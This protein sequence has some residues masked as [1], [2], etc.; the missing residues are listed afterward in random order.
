M[1]C[2]LKIESEHAGIQTKTEKQSK[3]NKK[4]DSLT[5]KIQNNISSLPFK[6]KPNNASLL[7][8]VWQKQLNVHLE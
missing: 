8:W 2:Y 4:T 6:S 1:L 7:V 5:A 3:Q